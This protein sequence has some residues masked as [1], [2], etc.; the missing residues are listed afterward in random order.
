MS[1]TVKLLHGGGLQVDDAGGRWVIFSL[2]ELR[3]RSIT[4]GAERVE[5]SPESSPNEADLFAWAAF[6]A[7]RGYAVAHG[8]IQD[9]RPVPKV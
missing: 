6:A 4:V 8:L 1:L 3:S 9:D 5:G 2:D 7:A